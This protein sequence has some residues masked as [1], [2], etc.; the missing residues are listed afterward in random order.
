M[1]RTTTN[2][3]ELSKRHRQSLSIIFL[4]CPLFKVQLCT[5]TS[6]VPSRPGDEEYACSPDLRGSV[7][8]CD[9]RRGGL[10]GPEAKNRTAIVFDT[11]RGP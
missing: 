8:K 10:L 2:Q 6:V 5:L 9:K 11:T 7:V 3:L 1:L 4:V